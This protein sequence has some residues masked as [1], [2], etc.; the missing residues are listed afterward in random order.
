MNINEIIEDLEDLI[1][2]CNKYVLDGPSD[3]ERVKRVA[4]QTLM[5]MK[6]YVDDCMD[7]KDAEV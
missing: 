3:T 5:W 6:H 1:E 2:E 4:T 7:E